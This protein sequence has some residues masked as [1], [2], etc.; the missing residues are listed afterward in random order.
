LDDN[1]GDFKV[2]GEALLPQLK[3]MGGALMNFNT[4]QIL[5]N[6]LASVPTDGAITL[7][8]TVPPN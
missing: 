2:L 6:F 3:G 5:S 1:G 8:V 4:G 7:H